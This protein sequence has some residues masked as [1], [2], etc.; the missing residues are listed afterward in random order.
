MQAGNW[1]LSLP[2]PFS[3]PTACAWNEKIAT[4]GRCQGKS[5]IARSALNLM[6]C[7]KGYSC[8]TILVFIDFHSIVLLC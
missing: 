8:G 3:N 7:K 6:K 2:P 4:G 5:E 1:A